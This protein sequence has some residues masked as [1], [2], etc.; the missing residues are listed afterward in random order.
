MLAQTK[1]NSSIYS[2]FPSGFCSGA[3]MP[4]PNSALHETTPLK[5]ESPLAAVALIHPDVFW[6]SPGRQSSHGKS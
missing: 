4:Y 6:S 3:R 5:F 2:V 1:T